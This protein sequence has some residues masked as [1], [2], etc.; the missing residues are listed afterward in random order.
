MDDCE[1]MGYYYE[2][3]LRM[4][5]VEAEAKN[6]LKEYEGKIETSKPEI[7]SELKEFG[8]EVVGIKVENVVVWDNG[9]IDIDFGVMI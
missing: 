4:D 1:L 5:S 2:R 3:G 6:L 8:R 7:V 9:S